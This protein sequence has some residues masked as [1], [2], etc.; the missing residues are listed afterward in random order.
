MKILV[1]LK[2]DAAADAAISQFVSRELT[3]L[4]GPEPMSVSIVMSGGRGFA[5]GENYTNAL[6]PLADNLGA[7]CVHRE[8]KPMPASPERLPD[9]PTGKTVAPPLFVTVGI[10][11][12]IQ[13]SA[14]HER[15]QHRDQQ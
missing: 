15:R 10:S 5:N 7:H 9:R 3:K 2:N 6:G 8:R 1:A 11:D 14:A 13:R 12:A 4:D